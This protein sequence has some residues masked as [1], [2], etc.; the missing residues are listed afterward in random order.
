MGVD[1]AAWC[2]YKYLNGGPGA[3][4]G[5]FIHEKYDNKNLN[6]LEGWWGHEKNDRF[7][8]PKVFCS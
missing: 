3:P 5:I 2:G 1:F 8:P 6:R 4:S 7:N